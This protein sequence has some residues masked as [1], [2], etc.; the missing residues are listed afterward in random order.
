MSLV[1]ALKK[2]SQPNSGP[3][4]K[5]KIVYLD[6]ALRLLVEA[7]ASFPK[8]RDYMASSNVGS[9]DEFHLLEDLYKWKKRVF[10][11]AP[12]GPRGESPAGEESPSRGRDTVPAPPSIPKGD[13]WNTCPAKGCDSDC[14]NCKGYWTIWDNCIHF[15]NPHNLYRD[16]GFVVN[17][18]KPPASP[19]KPS[20]KIEG[21][22]P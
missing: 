5:V 10:G 9:L 12:L 11:G 14:Q 19:A 22:N 18:W 8:E 15:R 17:T 21:R 1:H 2:I 16:K 20:L 13:E 4:D 7:A 3:D 6:D